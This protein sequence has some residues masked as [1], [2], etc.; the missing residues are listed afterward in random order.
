MSFARTQNSF[1]FIVYRAMPASIALYAIWLL[2]TGAPVLPG[3]APHQPIPSSEAP[4]RPPFAGDDDY[5]P[6]E[7]PPIEA[8]KGPTN[9]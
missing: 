1:E 5:I 9:H 4:P 2:A 3:D 6:G 8:P 7:R